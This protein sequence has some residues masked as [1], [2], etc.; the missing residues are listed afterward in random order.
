MAAEP[1]PR[2]RS[3]TDAFNIIRDPGAAAAARGDLMSMLERNRE[4]EA[5][6][7]A[8]A[9]SLPKLTERDLAALGQSDGNCPICLTSLLALLSEEEMALA[10]DSPAHPVEELGVTQLPP[11]CGHV[12]CRKDIRGWLYQGNTTCPTCRRPFIAPGSDEDA[13]VS[14]EAALLDDLLSGALARPIRFD[15][16][17]P[18]DVFPGMQGRPR[19]SAQ[20][21][22]DD[23]RGPDEPRE[24]HFDYDDD[25]SAYSGMYS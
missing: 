19:D 17:F 13:S 3:M 7:D 6:L 11:P 18:F 9:A 10:M 15:E 12:F 24:A 4:R 23:S 22:V 14:R 1:R 2:R 20:Q 8:F 16:H 25:R 21:P 5:Q